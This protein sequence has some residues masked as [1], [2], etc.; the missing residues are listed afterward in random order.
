MAKRDGQEPASGSSLKAAL[1]K[2]EQLLET[3]KFMKSE[4]HTIKCKKLDWIRIL[5][6]EKE[7]KGEWSI[8]RYPL[9]QA[10]VLMGPVFTLLLTLFL[11]MGLTAETLVGFVPLLG[12]N[13]LTWGHYI[14]ITGVGPRAISVSHVIL[15]IPIWT[16]RCTVLESRGLQLH[17]HVDISPPFEYPEVVLEKVNPTRAL[18]FRGESEGK[19]IVRGRGL[20]ELDFLL[21]EVSPS[22]LSHE[23]HA[24]FAIPVQESSEPSA[25]KFRERNVNWEP[26][27]RFNRWADSVLGVFLGVLFPE[28]EETDLILLNRIL[29]YQDLVFVLRERLNH[30]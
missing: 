6:A 10:R 20:K 15:G 26:S 5:P 17:L 25:V 28:E 14:R 1:N 21:R 13:L 3:R 2:V 16:T 29:G 8:V 22:I 11:F 24:F 9:L 4:E 23:V 30:G 27:K 18:E 12:L 19:Y 7:G